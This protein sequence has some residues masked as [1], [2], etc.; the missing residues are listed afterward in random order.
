M[1]IGD[2]IGDRPG[3]SVAIIDVPAILPVFRIGGGP[4]KCTVIGTTFPFKVLV[5]C[6]ILLSFLAHGG[7]AQ[8]NLSEIGRIFMWNR[9]ELAALSYI[10]DPTRAFIGDRERRALT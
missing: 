5:C 2:A 1:Q 9:I 4:V 7:H 3:V 6:S 8:H 10:T